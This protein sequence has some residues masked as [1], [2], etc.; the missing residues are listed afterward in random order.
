MDIA[1]CAAAPCQNGGLCLEL[2]NATLYSDGGLADADPTVMSGLPGD[3]RSI[4]SGPFDYANAAGYV[5]SCLSG[6]EG[7]CMR[8]ERGTLSRGL[9]CYI[10]VPVPHML[11]K[12]F[13]FIF[14]K[15]ESVGNLFFFLCTPKRG[16]MQHLSCTYYV[17]PPPPVLL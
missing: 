16:I 2:S 12:D 13:F 4:F 3:V 6:Y 17:C 8:K 11:H 1:E 15:N 7:G 14:F 10:Y 5:C 9:T